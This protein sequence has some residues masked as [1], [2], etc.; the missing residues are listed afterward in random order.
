[1]HGRARV[2][3]SLLVRTHSVPAHGC[4][5]PPANQSVRR[6]PGCVCRGREGA[7][8]ACA[9]SEP[10]KCHAQGCAAVVLHSLMCSPDAVAVAT[11]VAKE[12]QLSRP[13]V[14]KLLSRIDTKAQAPFSEP[15]LP[16]VGSFTRLNQ[17]SARN[18]ALRLKQDEGEGEGE[19]A[20]GAAAGAS[21]K[22]KGWSVD[23]NKLKRQRKRRCPSVAGVN[24]EGGGAG[25]ARRKR[26]RPSGGEHLRARACL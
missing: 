4:C 26:V 20:G 24:E 6:A 7:S 21:G 17:L 8:L 25:G 9:L 13:V 19:D 1:M 22:R 2:H 16:S 12:C 14:A 15:L 23:V 11:R 5:E 18:R 3:M 10:A